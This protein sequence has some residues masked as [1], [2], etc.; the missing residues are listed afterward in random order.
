[1]RSGQAGK[2]YGSPQTN[3]LRGQSLRRGA[4]LGSN[5]WRS[6]KNGGSGTRGCLASNP[7]ACLAER[8]GWAGD[9]GGDREHAHQ[10]IDATRGCELFA[11]SYRHRFSAGQ[12]R[13]VAGIASRPRFPV[14]TS[15]WWMIGLER[16][17]PPVAPLKDRNETA[18]GSRF[19][20]DAIA[21][22]RSW[23][24]VSIISRKVTPQLSSESHPLRR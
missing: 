14:W 5:R 17:A 24:A 3:G 2:T 10:A 23:D 12:E 13:T 15:G 11:C 19:S 21:D 16:E 20:T 6:L 8:R 9:R 1:M 18:R 4:P 22:R 7:R